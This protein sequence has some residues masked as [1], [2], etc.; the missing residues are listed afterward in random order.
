MPIDSSVKIA[1]LLPPLT[2]ETLVNG[3]AGLARHA[4][5]VVFIPHSTVGDVVV[6]RVT[7]VKKSFLEAE[8]CE[9]VKPAPQR[10]QP[11]CPVAGVCG[12]CQWQ[13]LPYSEQ[14]KW[15]ET[16]FRETLVRRCAISPDKVLPILSAV[17][18]WEYRSRVQIKCALRKGTFVCGFFR[19]KSHDVVAFD[20]CPL[21]VAPLNSLLSS[22]RQC[23]AE[24]PY[25][26]EIAQIDL[27]FDARNHRGAV[28]HYG[29][30]RVAALADFLRSTGIDADLL[31]KIPDRRT[32]LPVTG[33]G[34]FQIEVDQPPLALLYPAGSFAQINL[35]QNRVMVQKVLEYADLSG[36]ETVID[37]FC[38]MGNFSLPLARRSRAVIGIEASRRS[39]EMAKANCRNNNIDNATFHN[40][41]A[42][43]T[44]TEYGRVDLVVLDPPRNGAAEVMNE[45]VAAAV[46]KVIY[47]SCDPQTLARDLN[48]LVKGGYELVSS[49]SVDMF[50]Q[51]HHCESITVLEWGG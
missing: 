16:L 39:V 38:G 7:R 23:F 30:N 28:I 40:R 43:G 8:I 12:G 37:L 42:I 14:L 49:Q 32:L 48:V 2:I 36:S 1:D 5:R 13:H 21:V 45:L 47:V 51:T 34:I 15:K 35:D 50:P 29:G 31:L 6:V 25:C 22:L 3:G 9:I 27:L 46:K 33:T 4:G 20:H 44:L 41:S 18:E 10:R 11:V 24:S 19:P 26:N 17:Q